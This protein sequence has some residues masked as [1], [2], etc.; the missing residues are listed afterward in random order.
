MNTKNEQNSCILAIA[1]STR[2]FG[3]AVMEAND[4]LVNWGVKVVEGDKNKKSLE[5][6]ERIIAHYRPR[7]LVLEET[8]TKNTRRAPRIRELSKRIVELSKRYKVRVKIFSRKQIKRAFFAGGEGTKH[9]I[10]E[11]IAG[12]FPEDL[13]FQLPPKRRAWDSHNPRM[14]I[15]DAMALVMVYKGSKTKRIV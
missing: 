14:D 5:K 8:G 6:A 3:F 4:T 11:I 13:A 2:G 1:P 10:A 15:F 12:R 9:E 7:V